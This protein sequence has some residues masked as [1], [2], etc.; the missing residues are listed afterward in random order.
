MKLL[1]TT[2]LFVVVA[3]AGSDEQR[4]ARYLEELDDFILF[5][6][7]C[8]SQHRIVVIP[9][10]TSTRIRGLSLEDMRTAVCR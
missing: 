9:H 5:V 7:G 10:R 3:C 6:Q 8:E 4:Q 1:F 2:I